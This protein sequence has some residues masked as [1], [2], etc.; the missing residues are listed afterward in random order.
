MHG[1]V[2]DAVPSGSTGSGMIDQTMSTYRRK[3]NPAMQLPPGG[4]PQV[5]MPPS[6][7]ARGPVQLSLIGAPSAQQPP[8]PPPPAVNPTPE[9]P[10]AEDPA[11]EDPPD[12]P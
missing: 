9:N 5:I 1:E 10:P 11:P 6:A 12:N 2:A 4:A 7:P 8:P 3:F